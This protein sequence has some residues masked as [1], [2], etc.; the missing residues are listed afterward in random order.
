VPGEDCGGDRWGSMLARTLPIWREMSGQDA[1]SRF[2][3]IDYIVDKSAGFTRDP[4][5]ALTG[6]PNVS[7]QVPQ[8]FPGGCVTAGVF[9]ANGS[10]VRTL[11][12]EYE[13]KG[14]DALHLH[15][16]G[17]D[18]LRH[19]V[20]PGAYV[21]K[22][23][24]PGL[25]VEQSWLANTYGTYDG[26][27][28]QD[29][30]G[31]VVCPDGTSLGICGW[32]ES[33]GEIK[34]Y[35]PDGTSH[36]LQQVDLHGW[37]R[38]G[39]SE[40]S[41]DDKY[42]YARMQQ[43]GDDGGKYPVQNMNGLFRYPPKGNV[44]ACI[45]RYTL[46]GQP[47][48]FAKGYGIDGS[49]LMLQEVPKKEAL[50]PGFAQGGLAAGGGKLFVSDPQN[51]QVHAYD[52]ETLDEL[53][54]WNVP[55]PGRLAWDGK[56]ALW[57]L[58]QDVLGESKKG[59]VY[60]DIPPGS[61]SIHKI[62]LQTGSV[63]TLSL[64][65]V[66]RASAL[67]FDR[68]GRLLI[69]DDG[70]DMQ[71]KTFNL[72]G[73]TPKLIDT[74]GQKGGIYAGEEGKVAPDK[75]N[76]ITGVG[77]DSAGNIYV[78]STHAGGELRK[79]SPDKKLLWHD[80]GLAFVD[81]ASADPQSPEDVFMRDEHFKVDYSTHPVSWKYADFTSDLRKPDP[82]GKRGWASN[83]V[84]RIGGQ[85]FMF[86]TAMFPQAGL[87]IY[88]FEGNLTAMCGF[89]K[90]EGKDAEVWRDTN[91]DGQVDPSEC[92]DP[93]TSAVTAPFVPQAGD[94]GSWNWFVDTRGDIWKAYNKAGILHIP[95][96]G[97]DAHGNPIYDLKNAQA[98]PM[99]EPFRE[100]H[101]VEYI[102]KTDTLYVGGETDEFKRN[103]RDGWGPT[104]RVIA[105]YDAKTKLRWITPVDTYN[106]I[107]ISV[108]NDLIFADDMLSAS[109]QIFD[110]KIG[111]K[112]GTA[113]V[114]KPAGYASGWNDFPMCIRA[115]SL[116]NGDSVVFVEEDWCA[117]IV[118]YRVHPNI[119]ELTSSAFTLAASQR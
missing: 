99:P 71:V 113:A 46:N 18:N 101:T 43:S 9:R 26:H 93:R 31:L 3:R 37:G 114:G 107:A 75:F 51:N 44:W 57:V 60:R 5:G 73:G 50:L 40:I 66:G 119:K 100:L 42:I 38:G 85:R 12:S 41:A 45:R 29:I 89:I 49:F 118:L 112:L 25:S 102:P 27:V 32:D 13:A 30:L 98:L 48:P 92:Q 21:I 103:P 35:F 4:E 82:I 22:M 79:F 104:T 58:D 78:S 87:A 108:T 33:G 76:G 61:A 54:S 7:L 96:S 39:S 20:D 74:L 88:K 68:S 64:P 62:D 24:A 15:W 52:R 67:A 10:P 116:K 8:S 1:N 70:S 81:G 63:T 105:R 53:Q 84:R 95:C 14:G 17:T 34:K 80:M 77:G 59:E 56:G 94:H 6:A 69:G 91:G 2:E 86:C 72:S 111:V 16:D 115:I 90:L 117:K 36:L 109:L 47:A 106:C 65:G 110:N 19:A 97:L 83:L 11:V 55:N 23:I 28:Q